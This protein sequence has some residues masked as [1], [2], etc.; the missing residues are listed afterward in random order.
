[1]DIIFNP[2]T[3]DFPIFLQ[4]ISVNILAKLGG[5]QITFDNKAAEINLCKYISFVNY[6]RN[7]FF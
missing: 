2:H 5:L 7:F 6:L 3:T 1:M 4:N